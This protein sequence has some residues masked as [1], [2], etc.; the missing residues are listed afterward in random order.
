MDVVWLFPSSISPCSAS[1]DSPLTLLIAILFLRD[2]GIV[3]DKVKAPDE[4][5]EI[6]TASFSVQ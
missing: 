4:A 1:A 3:H 5:D 6:E 2:T